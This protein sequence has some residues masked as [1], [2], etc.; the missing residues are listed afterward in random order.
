MPGKGLIGG[1]VPQIILN[2]KLFKP[3]ELYTL[4][5]TGLQNFCRHE[6]VGCS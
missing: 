4:H 6:T 1:A 2:P 5:N 3:S